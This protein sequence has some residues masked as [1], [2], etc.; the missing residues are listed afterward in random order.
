MFRRRGVLVRA[1]QRVATTRS[2][3]D[4]PGRDAQARAPAPARAP[5]ALGGGHGRRRGRLRVRGAR[6]RRRHAR[7]GPADSLDLVAALAVP[8]RR[9]QRAPHQPLGM[10]RRGRARDRRGGVPL[11]GR[12]HPRDPGRVEPFV[13][14]RRPAHRRV[15]ARRRRA[16]AHHVGVGARRF[17]GWLRARCSARARCSRRP[18]STTSATAS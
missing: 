16:G 13:A 6:A 14:H 7:A 9:D 2:R 18:S 5:P 8:R 10:D 17:S 4:R 11:H 12:A 1:E 15:R 3:A